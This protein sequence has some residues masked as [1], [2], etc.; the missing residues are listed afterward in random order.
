MIPL[1]PLD[2]I[3]LIAARKHP[4]PGV[5]AGFVALAAERGW[6]LGCQ[7]VQN[8]DE[9]RRE[10]IG[11][12]WWETWLY[13]HEDSHYVALQVPVGEQ[14]RMPWPSG[15]YPELWDAFLRLADAEWQRLT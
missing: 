3:A 4:V 1:E 7:W 2:A 12:G 13:R 15:G 14:C 11:P 10:F 5:P 6:K 9:E 8:W